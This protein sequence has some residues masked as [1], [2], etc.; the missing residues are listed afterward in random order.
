MNKKIFFVAFILGLI[1]SFGQP[2]FNYT[3]SS[4][5]SIALFFYFI[6]NA[7]NS[8]ESAWVSFSFGYGYYIYS[9]HWFSESLLAYGDELLWLYPFGLLLI[10]AFFALYF[11]LAGLCIFKY[12]K[13]NIFNAALI[14]LAMELVRSYGYIELPWLLIGYIWS[15]TEIMSQSASLFGIYGLSFLSIIWAGAIKEAFYLIRGKGLCLAFF[16]FIACY[17]YGIYHLQAPTAEQHINIRLIQPNIDQNI[18][19]RINNRY[20]N[21][22]KILAMSKNNE[23]I[24]YVIWPEGSNEYNL[25]QQLL[26]LIKNAAPKN[27]T[28]IFSSNRVIQDPLEIWNSLFIINNDGKII[29]YYDK[30]HLVPLGE[31]IPLRSLLPF[32]NKI[33]PGALD[34]S[35]GRETK[36]IK[37]AHPFAP[38]ICYEA[39]FS[40]YNQQFY[41]WIVNLTNDGWFGRSIGPKQH[42]A[43]AKFRSIE[44]GVPMARSALT[45]VSAVIDSFGHIVKSVPLL[46]EGVIDAKLPDYIIGFTYYHNYGYYML[47]LL[48]LAIFILYNLKSS[49][50]AQK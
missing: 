16:S 49:K 42:L 18:Q 43:I 45:G 6:E 4:L 31:F 34:F 26:D 25:N 48:I 44:Q 39:T 38:N 23:N 47:A 19:S 11:A 10:P 27:G 28:L 20:E 13:N 32:I 1:C 5:C 40:D 30:I 9:H 14:W 35:R 2:P 7:K 22:I 29:D 37:A 15:N 3:I 41:T 17:V 24:D 8:K 36:A 46:T 33:T 50:Y 21:L 12:A